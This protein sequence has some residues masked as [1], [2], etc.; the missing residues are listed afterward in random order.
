[1]KFRHNNQG[2]DN[3][4]F[5]FNMHFE[6][7]EDDYFDDNDDETKDG[8]RRC[9]HGHMMLN[10]ITARPIVDDDGE[11]AKATTASVK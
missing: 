10:N 2:Q 6:E 8:D 7:W 3:S 1:M 5:R 11:W 9:L 4:I